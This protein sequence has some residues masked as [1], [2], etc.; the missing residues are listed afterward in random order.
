MKSQDIEKSI[1]SK[2]WD[3]RVQ[4][5]GFLQSKLIVTEAI[6]QKVFLTK[7]IFIHDK[8]NIWVNTSA[9][10][11]L[12]SYNT[13]ITKLFPMAFKENK[14]WPLQIYDDLKKTSQKTVKLIKIFQNT[15]WVKINLKEKLKYLNSYAQVLYDIQKY[16]S[17]AVPLT[18]YCEEQLKVQKIPF[19]KYAVQYRALDVDKMNYSLSKIKK[20][21]AKVSKKEL[22]KIINHHLANFAWIKTNYNIVEKYSVKEVTK[23]IQSYIPI[24]KQAKI[25]N[26]PYKYIITG[27]QVEIYLRN[28]IKELSQQLWFS[29]EGLAQELAK[30]LLIPKSDFLQLSYQEVKEAFKQNTL[31]IS[32][33]KLNA[34]HKGFIT[35]ILNGQRIIL[36]GKVVNSF[37][38]FFNKKILQKK[39]FVSGTTACSGL[40]KGKVRIIHK[41][42]E[43][44]KLKN[45]E[46]LVT[47]MTTPDY[48]VSMKKAGAIVTDEG[49][50]SCHAAIVSRELGIPC[51]IGTKIA[52]KVLKDGDLIEVNANTGI[53]RLLKKKA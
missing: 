32:K 6:N 38:N 15:N 11:D 30:N 14:N 28:R 9:L 17:I 46:I 16:Y 5:P 31:A 19:L 51:I 37:F 25:P 43:M 33:S 20:L 35:G 23:E 49:G 50:L 13:L 8:N 27:L 2:N 10:Y 7:N 48:I 52:T 4:R 12:N 1:Y 45:G 39:S 34:R 26:S 44:G 40:A 22:N 18:N 41:I 36:T 24:F 3:N 29:Y 42:S 21:K 53:I 47:T